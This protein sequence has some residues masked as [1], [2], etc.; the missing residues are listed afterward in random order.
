[1]ILGGV[2]KRLDYYFAVPSILWF[3]DLFTK[4]VLSLG[5]FGH[6][7]QSYSTS[8]TMQY[9]FCVWACILSLLLFLGRPKILMNTFSFFILWAIY[10][11][12]MAAGDRFMQF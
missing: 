6:L 12:H 8:D 7:F 2:F 4:H 1:M 10:L 9:L 5:G 11:S 3:E